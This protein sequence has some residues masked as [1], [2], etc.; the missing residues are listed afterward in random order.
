[1]ELDVPHLLVPGDRQ[2]EA[3]A[4]TP[5]RELRIL[6]EHEWLTDAGFAAD[7]RGQ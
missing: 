6:C 2:G 5:M 7:V 4:D 1:V 3:I